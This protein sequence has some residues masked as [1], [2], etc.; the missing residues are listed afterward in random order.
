MTNPSFIDAFSQAF[1][2]DIESSA[3]I[4]ID[5]QNAT[6]NRGMGLGK[7]LTE[8]GEDARATYRYDRIETVLEPNIGT[9]LD[10]FRAAGGHIIYITYGANRA[11]G[12]DAPAHMAP[13]IRATN[14]IAGQPEHEIVDALKPKTGELVLNKITQ[15]AFRSTA[16]DSTLR[17]LGVRTVIATGVS[18]NNCVAMTAMEACDLQYQ[19]VVVEDA[20]GTDSDE[21]QQATLTMLRRLWSRVMSTQELIAELNAASGA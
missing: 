18:T 10:Y 6:G 14:N 16:L 2:P 13:I 20:T 8:R 12:E 7:L 17:A 3:L 11:D 4:V 19:V 21:M 9:L 5:M 1:T 15:G